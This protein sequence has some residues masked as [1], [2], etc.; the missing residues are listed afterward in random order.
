MKGTITLFMLAV[1]VTCSGNVFGKENDNEALPELGTIEVLDL[2][3]AQQI[4]IGS[5]PT[6]EAAM[7]R[8][9]QAKARVD[10]AMSTWWPA[11]NLDGIGSR[12]RL[13]DT[14]FQ[15]AQVFSS[16][17]GESADRNTNDYTINLRAS[18]TL[19]DGFY[20]TYSQEQAKYGK[21]SVDESRRNAARLLVS[22]VAEAFYNAQLA[23]T[24][25]AI[26]EADSEFYRQQLRDAQNRYDVGAGP[27][28]DVLNIKVQLNS[29]KTNLMVSSREHEAAVY[30]LAALMGLQDAQLPDHIRLEELDTEIEE[31]GVNENIELLID[32]AL[33][34]R[35]DIKEIDLRAKQ[36]HATVG[37]AKAQY[38]PKL[39]VVGFVNREHQDNS[40]FS[41]DDFGNTVA[42]NLSWNLFTGGADKARQIEAE[43]V[44]REVDST[45][46]NLRN[47][48]V[49]EVRQ[50]VVLLE[51]AREQVRLQR[52][53]VKLVEENRDLAKNEYEAGEASL[54]RLNEA[55]RDL[56]TTYSR[57]VQAVV[58]F[59]RANQRVLTATGRN[60]LQFEKGLLTEQ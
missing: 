52:E 35:P 44:I 59:H 5:N 29:A 21:Q 55:Q 26:A 24:Q 19:F 16:L 57:L 3:T 48:I 37:M 15:S 38:Y 34:S 18:W 9:E 54:V 50:S 49:S 39:E 22:S 7:A 43:Q 41:G 20:R 30:G 12:N 58:T 17:Y 33:V 32:E 36:A 25:V 2:G 42:L 1:F 6:M 40:A 27:W 13:S 60:F 46:A 31:D 51:A 4:A 23:K 28:G 45:L 14:A 47:E 56:T 10:Q 8:V 11:L 53:S